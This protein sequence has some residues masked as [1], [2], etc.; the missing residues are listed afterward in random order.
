MA[1][2]TVS[3]TS[4]RPPACATSRTSSAPRRARARS[5]RPTQNSKARWVSSSISPSPGSKP[6]RRCT[7][8][9]RGPPGAR[10]FRRAPTSTP[11]PRIRWRPR[12]PR[13]PGRD[14]RRRHGRSGTPVV[15]RS[16]RW[17][18]APDVDGD[19]VSHGNAFGWTSVY[20]VDAGGRPRCVVRREP[21]PSGHAVDRADLVDRRRRRV[22]AHASAGRWRHETTA[23]VAAR[24]D[25][26]R[27]AARR[28]AHRQPRQRHEPPTT[29]LDDA[30]AV[31]TPGTRYEARGS[32]GV[33]RPRCP[34]TGRRSRSRTRGRT[35]L[36]VD[37]TV[38]PDD[39]SAPIEQTLKRR[40]SSV[41]VTPRAALGAPGGLVVETFAPSVVV[42]SG[43]EAADQLAVNA[44]RR[45]R[46][47]R[48]TSRRA[49]PY[50]APING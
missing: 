47:P 26:A 37:L 3:G 25:V 10:R 35:R 23:A 14:G 15:G 8:T 30:A 21:P 50:A 33:S 34:P 18:V 41:S 22:A 43:I 7:R 9:R 16:G 36:R 38:W 46:P 49:R 32:A 19:A 39:G 2:P 5:G 40:A 6:A 1:R 45:A 4:S 11:A 24:A 13:T 29:K 42:E 44:S 20:A 17:T 27:A 31:A 48:G 28:G 12:S